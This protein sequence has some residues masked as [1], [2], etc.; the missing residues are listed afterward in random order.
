[1]L[2]EMSGTQKSQIEGHESNASISYDGTT[3]GVPQ[4]S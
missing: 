1:M 3:L 2:G 4:N